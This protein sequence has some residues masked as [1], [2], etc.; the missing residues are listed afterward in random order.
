MPG[1]VAAARTKPRKTRAITTFSFQSA[2]ANATIE[3]TTIV[4]TAALLH[5][6]DKMLPAED[7]L[8]ALGHGAAG[9]E[10]LRQRGYDELAPAVASHPVMEIGG[11]PTY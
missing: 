4:E 7:P 11:A 8:K 1:R 5:D 6:L 2:S 10:W 9:A 3:I